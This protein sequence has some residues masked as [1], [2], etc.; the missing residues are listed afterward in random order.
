[1][2]A[3][4]LDQTARE[5]RSTVIARLGVLERAGDPSLTALTR[6]AAYVSGARAATIEILDDERRHRIA[7]T[8]APLG[9]HDGQDSARLV[10][11]LPLQTS[12]DVVIGTLCAFDT[13]ELSLDDEQLARLQEL[14]DQAVAQIE[15]T[16]VAVDLGH[17]ASHDPLTG[18]VNRLVLGDRLAQAFARRGRHGGETFLALLDVAGLEPITGAHGR[19]AADQVLVEIARRLRAAMRAEDT[20]ARIRLDRFAVLAELMAPVDIEH[21]LAERIASALAPPIA[22]AAVSRPIPVSIGCVLAKPGEQLRELLARA[23]AASAARR[24]AVLALDS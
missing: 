12:E 4:D 16:R 23:D 1:M 11:S 8:G 6:L 13:R 7:A 10:A 21:E 5:R 2:V 3:P 19:D 9:E 24:Q 18:A 15:L 20:V 17:L 22:Y 14:A